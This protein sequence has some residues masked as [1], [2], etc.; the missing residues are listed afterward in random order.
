MKKKQI[1]TIVAIEKALWSHVKQEWFSFKCRWDGINNFLCYESTITQIDGIVNGKS[2]S[3]STSNRRQQ[4]QQYQQ[5]QQSILDN[6]NCM[7]KY[8]GG[9]S[10]SFVRTVAMSMAQELIATRLR[11]QVVASFVTKS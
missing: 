1:V 6:A 8:V 4:Y 5:Y 9:N 11:Q 3:K 2:T 10:A 7:V